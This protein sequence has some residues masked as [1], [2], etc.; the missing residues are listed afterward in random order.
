[1]VII[2][3]FYWKEFHD[4]GDYLESHSQKEAYQRSAVGRYYYSW[5]HLVKDYFEKKYFSLGFQDNTH[6]TLIDCLKS[7]GNEID[8]NLADALGKLRRYRNKADY[9]Q[10]F[11]ENILRNAKKTTEDIYLLL[12]KVK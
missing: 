6:K 12:E 1:M 4:V 11:R 9:Y 2:M 3:S 7:R 10:G 8:V 5:Y